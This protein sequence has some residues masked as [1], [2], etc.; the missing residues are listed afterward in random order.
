MNQPVSIRLLAATNNDRGDLFTRLTKDLFFALGYDDLRLDVHKSGRELDIQGKHRFEP[1]QVVGECKA[2]KKKMGGDELNKFLGA[3]TRER[4]K[5]A[6]APVAGYFISLGGFTETGIEQELE[7]GDDC[8][9]LL[10]A[11]NVID[12][13]QRSHVIV[14]KIV[15]AERAGQCAEHAGLRDAALDG[16]ELLG[17]HTGYIWAVY[18]AQGKARTHFALIHADGTALAESI[19]KEVIDAD[20]KCKGKLH[21]LIYLR[22]QISTQDGEAL[23]KSALAHYRNWIGEEFG[24]IQLDG[25]PA[26]TDLS[27]TRLKLEKLFVP[28]KAILA[29]DDD[30]DLEEQK[31]SKVITIGELLKGTPHIALLAMPGGG[32]ST[33]L[34]RLATAYA[35]P[36]RDDKLSDE[37]PANDWQPL[38]LRCRELRDRARRPILELLDDIPRH[39]GMSK[40][41]CEVFHDFVHEQLQAGNILLLV[42]GLD[43]ISDEGDRQTFASHLRTF[44]AMFPQ[45]AL[46]VTSR[47]A[48]FRLVAGVVAGVCQQAKLAPFDE[49]DVLD[50]TVRWSVE[51]VGNSEKVRTE[52]TELGQAIWNN[53]S[54]RTLTQNPLLLTTLL[55]VKRC[56]GELPRSRT[57]LYREAIRVLVRTWNVE[58]YAP[59]DEDETLAQLSYVACA[60]ME[61]GKQRIEQKSLLKLLQ[62]AR[63]ELEAELQFARISPQEFIE[64]I[65]YRSSLLMQTGHEK[66]DDELQA[67]FEFRHLT[68]Q[69][70]LAARGYVEEQY[71]GRNDGK[72]LSKM[73]EGHFSDERWREVISLAAVLAGRKAEDLIKKLTVACNQESAERSNLRVIGKDP[74]VNLLS[75]CIRDEVQVTQPTLK[76][77]LSEL[78]KGISAIGKGD[79]FETKVFSNIL[80][81]KFA[82][83]FRDVVEQI[84]LLGNQGFE[85]YAVAMSRLALYDWFVDEYPIMTKDI[86]ENLHAALLADNRLERIRAALVIMVLAYYPES[87]IKRS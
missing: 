86:A 57:A 26:D 22:P 48:G 53:R 28:L 40:D 37:L 44:V 29:S 23:L 24:Y 4:K 84:Y 10:N 67:I 27:A 21:T 66:I 11:G 3:L 56:V 60:M 47:E 78:A 31:P 52:A 71:P 59:M 18:Y 34:K 46:I 50:L 69:E 76:E 42:D 17:H 49:D 25:L 55:V 87:R 64:R 83:L 63:R 68:F 7:T 13:L 35:F 77:A 39:A 54:I 1:R 15:A 38:I 82:V 5:S 80:H 32:K 81:G 19:A 2:H 70:Y 33:L 72:A 62:N 85:Q 65:E 61:E 9:I 73:L 6:P 45:V 58:G 8:V 51:V 36:E 41:E 14:S 12:E 43:E 75:Q 16:V 20:R 74:L 79:R 30:K